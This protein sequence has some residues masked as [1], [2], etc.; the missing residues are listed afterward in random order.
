MATDKKYHIGRDGTPKVCTAK[1]ECKLGGKHFDN[2]EAAQKYADELNE[3]NI[4]A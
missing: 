1:G 3:K 2:L 4:K